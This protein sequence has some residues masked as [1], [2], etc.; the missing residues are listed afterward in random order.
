MDS[1]DCLPHFF[2]SKH[3]QHSASYLNNINVL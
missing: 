3:V 2:F 1:A